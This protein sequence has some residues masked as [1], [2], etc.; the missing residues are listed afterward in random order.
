[1]KL[2]G[3][4]VFFALLAVL[5]L[6]GATLAQG[7]AVLWDGNQWPQM[8]Y[9]AK[10]GYVAGVGNMADFET[11]AGKGKYAVVSRALSAELKTRTVGQIIDEVDKYYKENPGKLE[12][13]VLEVILMR[14]TKARPPGLVEGVK[15]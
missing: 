2:M 13:T 3:K 8:P 7:K 11:A 5:V 12:T 9:D 1:M 4:A 15:K 6:A 14:C 10:V